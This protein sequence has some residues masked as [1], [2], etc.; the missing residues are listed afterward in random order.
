MLSGLRLDERLGAD[1]PRRAVAARI[2]AMIDDVTFE[3]IC[4]RLALEPP[5][6]RY[7]PLWIDG[8]APG[9]VSDARAE[10]LRG[11]PAVFKVEDKRISF[12]PALSSAAA[13]TGALA[14]VA[15]TLASD[16][17]LSAWRNEVYACAPEFGAPA[18]FCIERAAARYF[19]IQTWAVHV[20]GLVRDDNGIRM[21]LARRS[22]HKAIDPGLLDNLVGGGISAGES[23]ASA[24]LRESWEEAGLPAAIA[25]GGAHCATVSVC[26]ERP[27]GLQ[28]E[29]IFVHDLWLPMTFIPANQDAEAIGHRLVSLPEVARL[30]GAPAGPDQIT[31]D[32][33][34]V[35]VD[36]LRRLHGCDAE[37]LIGLLACADAGHWLLKH[38]VRA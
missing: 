35:A 6:L 5:A 23:V 30:I 19:G 31:I 4:A 3:R 34:V 24:L 29:T 1:S 22:A 32:A 12:V 15:T 18:W 28:R 20:N 25:G 38:L 33:S 16:G 27:D 13:R 21:W 2:A 14:N 10:R 8:Y 36:C 26:R 11:F 9:W 7:R 37:S 17:V